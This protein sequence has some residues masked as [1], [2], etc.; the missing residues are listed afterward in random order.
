MSPQES[1]S[2]TL[3]CKL[4][5]EALY[6]PHRRFIAVA[7]VQVALK[8]FNIA[9]LSRPVPLPSH[10]KR[11]EGCLPPLQESEVA[12]HSQLSAA[13]AERDALAAANERLR[14]ELAA[15]EVQL[16]HLDAASE[17]QYRCRY[18]ESS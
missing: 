14:E 17:Q 13:L 18:T 4:S 16:E 8:P 12:A 9:Q 5:P 6:K 7:G 11:L 3:S 2:G 10:C 15:R 1:L